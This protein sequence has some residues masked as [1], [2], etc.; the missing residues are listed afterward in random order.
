MKCNLKWPVTN[1]M[2]WAKNTYL[3]ILAWYA[4][5]E[6]DG[7]NLRALSLATTALDFPTCCFWNK[8]CRFKLLTSIVSRSIWKKQEPNDRNC[9]G[10]DTNT[11]VH[12]F[13]VM[14]RDTCSS[15]RFFSVTLRPVVYLLILE[16][17]IIN[18][19]YPSVICLEINRTSISN[20]L[21][22]AINCI[23]HA[24]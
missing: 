20:F 10:T 7:L 12:K 18:T 23:A 13:T 16:E 22:A 6:T 17:Y 4:L 2:T 14:G 8:N 19:S 15:S 9:N 5:I 24:W 3:I 21:E 1:E 11:H